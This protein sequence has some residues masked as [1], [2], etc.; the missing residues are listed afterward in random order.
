MIT[1]LT[2]TEYSF[3]DS[4]ALSVSNA[5]NMY[6]DTTNNTYATVTHT[7]SNSTA[8]YFYVHGFNFSLVP[9]NAN[10]TSFTVKI[11]AR[12]SQLSTSSSYRMRLSYKPDDIW[13][14]ISN[15]TVSS[16]LSTSATVFTFPISSFITWDKLR[17]KGD[18]GWG[19]NFAIRVGLRRS[20]SRTTGYAYIYGAEVEV[21]WEIPTEKL[22]YKSSGS[23]VEVSKA[24]KKINGVW[25]EQTDLTTVFNSNTNYVKGN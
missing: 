14:T 12:E 2:P 5:S 4:T 16:S 10:V 25:V 8:Y 9:A 21:N 20:S 23:W 1:V 13:T 11:R 19:S 3:S 15:T 6:N 7:K 22:Y 18:S 24:Y 17:N